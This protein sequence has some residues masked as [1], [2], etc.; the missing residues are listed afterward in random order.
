VRILV[1]TDQWFP[2]CIGGVA[3]V[4]TDTARHWAGAGHEVVVIAPRHDGHAPEETSV[5][6]G[7]T[8]LRVLPRGRLP[9]TLTDPPAARRWASRLAHQGFDVLVS[10][11]CTTACGFL[12]ARLGLPLVYV[13]HADAAEEARYLR[14]TL[15]PGAEWLSAAAIA[16]PLQSLDGIALRRASAVVVL[17]EF[18][19]RLLSAR[20]PAVAQRAVRVSGGVDTAVFSPNGRDEA[21]QRLGVDS[22][23]RLVFTVRRLEPRMG[24]E[25]LLEAVAMLDDVEDF[26]VAIAGS[27]GLALRDRADRLGLDDR[28]ELLGRVSDDDL[29]LWHKAA[30]LFVL[31]SVAYEGFGLVT[32][33]A[34]AC[35]T[36]VVGTP[37]GAT[38]ELL[39][40]LDSRLLARG[41]D[42]ATLA[43]AIQTGLRIA[44]PAFRARCRDYALPRFA[45]DT[46]ISDWSQILEDAAVPHRRE[47]ELMEAGHLR[48]ACVAPR[49]RP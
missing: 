24:L 18:S 8:L 36:P 28:V 41:I 12:A 23:T 39:E 2:D 22:S 31:P 27:G 33:E 4:A 19:R 40:P 26:R 17:S 20:A 38:P 42:P 1:A 44:T 29:P 45:W 15:R 37:I 48:T 10:H 46:V 11:E 5:N 6:D 21:R 9:Q 3:R 47:P 25:N 7:L 14:T 34:L 35:G 49:V 32:A 13:F 16:R 43:A 30:D